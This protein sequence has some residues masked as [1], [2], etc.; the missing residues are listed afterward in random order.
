L[1]TIVTVSS[2]WLHTNCP[3]SMAQPTASVVGPSEGTCHHLSSPGPWHL[4]MGVRD[5]TPSPCPLPV[6]PGPDAQPTGPLVQPSPFH[7]CLA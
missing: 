6:S 2:P 5:W 4:M 1:V 7:S 3:G